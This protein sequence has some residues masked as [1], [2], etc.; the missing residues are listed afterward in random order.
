MKQ[1]W[2]NIVALAASNLGLKVLALVIAV[3]L[4]VAGHRDIER[5]IEVPVEFRNVPAD[6]I[7]LDNRVDYVVLRL[8]G[9]RTLVSTLDSD[10]VKLRIDL[11]GAKSGSISYPLGPSSFN[12]PRG[13][14]AARITPPV[15]HLRLEPVIRRTLPVQVKLSGKPIAGYQITSMMSQPETIAVSG[16]ADELKRLSAVETLP[17]DIDGGRGVIK[18]KVRL[19]TDGKPFSFLP[20]QVEVVVT[21]DEEESTREFAGIVVRARDFK[22]VFTVTPQSISLRVSGAKSLLDKLELKGDEAY[23]NLKGL[24]AGEHQLPLIV[25]LPAGFRVVEQKPQRVKVRITKPGA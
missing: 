22:G 7:V 18:R 25:E 23:L 14:T 3:G 20:D 2:E 16:P 24:P 21:V 1:F 15:V 13:V 11:S 5:A 17:V 10:D 4:W 19:S 9:P 6:L 8:T 12:V